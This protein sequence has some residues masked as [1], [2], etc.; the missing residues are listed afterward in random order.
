MAYEIQTTAG[1]PPA[2]VDL[3]NPLPADG[4]YKLYNEGIGGPDVAICGLKGSR[5]S[6]V[7]QYQNA[8]LHLVEVCSGQSTRNPANRIPTLMGGVVWSG[9]PN[10]WLAVYSGSNSCGLP[11]VP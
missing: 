1:A 9:A 8:L 11:S 10:V 2:G 3:T 6:W 4:C 7:N 5:I